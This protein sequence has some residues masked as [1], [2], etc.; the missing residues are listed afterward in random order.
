MLRCGYSFHNMLLSSHLSDADIDNV[1]KLAHAINIEDSENSELATKIL[2]AVSE[3]E[4][5]LSELSPAAANSP[6]DSFQPAPAVGTSVLEVFGFP[7]NSQNVDQHASPTATT[8]TNTTNAASSKQTTNSIKQKL[9]ETDLVSSNVKGIVQLRGTL[10][11]LYKD[12]LEGYNLQI[13]LERDTYDAAL[14]RYREINEQRGDP[15][16]STSIG[17][18]RKLSASWLPQLELL[19]EEEQQRCRQAM[20]NRSTDRKRASYGPFFQMLDSSKIAIITIMEAL[21]M[22]ASSMRTVL[23]RSTASNSEK[24]SKTLGTVLAISDAIHNEIRMERMKKRNNSHIF[25]RN[26]NVAK[27]ASSGKL[28]NM[29]IRRAQAKEVRESTGDLSWIDNWD[30]T[31]RMR[32]GSLLMSLLIE[33]AR[34][35]E[36]YTNTE[37]NVMAERMVPAFSHDYVFVKGRRVG[38]IVSHPVMRDIFSKESIVGIM[39]PRHLP[40]LVPPRPW[41][42]YNSGGYLLKDE[43]CMRIK[44]NYE[45]LRLLTQASNEDRLCTMLSGLDALGQTRWAINHAV[46]AAVT[47]VWNSGIA[48]A[49]IPAS[50][51]DIPEPE[52]PADYDTNKKARVEYHFKKVEWKNKRVNQHSMRC[53]CNYKVEIAKAFLNH[54]MYF[55]HNID[56]RGRAYPIPPH[57]NH[58]GNDL[59][60]GLLVFH[61]GRPLTKRGLFWLKIHLANLV[62]KD[63]LSHQERL[64]FIDAHEKEIMAC[65]DDPVPDPLIR[66]DPGAPRP[67]WVDSENPWQTLAACIDYTAAMRSPNPEEYVSQLHIH[68]DGTCN[69]LQHYAA[70]GRD[71]KGAKEVNLYPSDRPQDVYSGIL[72]VVIRRIDEDIEKGVEH[73]RK[74]QNHLTRKVVKQTV[75]TNV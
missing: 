69:G 17:E 63:K 73:A 75:M 48:L 53:D 60:R 20:E 45:Q 22:Q 13:R 34:V 30:T 32:I 71:I 11:S 66:K 41:L 21:R 68:Q 1:K 50:H 67:W 23:D 19:I 40:M 46:F 29:A 36:T 55:P 54:P 72:N 65:A 44:D 42:T 27:L 14:K 37:T 59:C 38:I 52:K 74:L 62:G 18:L 25:G 56:F 2:Q 3:A 58:L 35:P 24:G 51:I 64:E 28:F 49:D 16:L 9:K 8:D 47:K 10:Q 12:N 4:T 61:E 70:M 39:T 43:P 6:Q 15:L 31:V 26:V 7:Q 57:F 33:V 5:K